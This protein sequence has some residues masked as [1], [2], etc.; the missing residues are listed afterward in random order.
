VGKCLDVKNEIVLNVCN[1]IKSENP[2]KNISWI[3]SEIDEATGF[4]L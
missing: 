1:Y 4:T 3:M 2:E